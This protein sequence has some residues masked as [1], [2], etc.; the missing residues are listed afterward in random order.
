ML[1]GLQA[2][3]LYDKGDLVSLVD[4]SITGDDEV[5]EA[6]KYLKVALLCTQDMP[7]LRPTMSSVAD[8]LTGDVDVTDEKI[9]K[10]GLLS[11]LLGLKVNKGPRISETSSA[12]SSSVDCSSSFKGHMDTSHATM[13]FTSIYDRNN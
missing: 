3:E 12:D 13:S 11:E 6:H 10:P 4:T 8:M 9:S 1:M 5:K 2:W 7:K